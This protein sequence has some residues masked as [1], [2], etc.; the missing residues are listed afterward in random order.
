MILF[1]TQ[2]DSQRFSKLVGVHLTMCLGDV[3]AQ[4]NVRPED[5]WKTFDEWFPTWTQLQHAHLCQQVLPELE[6]MAHDHFRHQL[7]ALQEFVLYGAVEA[8][9]TQ[10]DGEF[11]RYVE[12]GDRTAAERLVPN[13]EVFAEML[14]SFGDANVTD[15]ELA[16]D[17]YAILDT[18]SPD[19]ASAQ[20]LLNRYSELL[21]KSIVAELT[22]IAGKARSA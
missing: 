7:T 5:Q 16:E 19:P 4:A 18:A 21:P 1:R 10:L 20:E 13:Q 6:A 22:S 15:E 14:E 17:V 12:A 8:F 2:A 11:D 3:E 9:A